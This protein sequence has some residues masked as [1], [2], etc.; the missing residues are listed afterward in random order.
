MIDRRTF[1]A[2]TAFAFLLGPPGSQA[3]QGR[4]SRVGFLAPGPGNPHEE[5]F[6]SSMRLSNEK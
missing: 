3:Q 1:L 6:I 2:S 4:V 5:S